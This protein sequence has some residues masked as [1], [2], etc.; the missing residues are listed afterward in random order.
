MLE[1]VF[2]LLWG[3]SNVSFYFDNK[4]LRVEADDESARQEMFDEVTRQC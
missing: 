3:G 4:H 1:G 2:E